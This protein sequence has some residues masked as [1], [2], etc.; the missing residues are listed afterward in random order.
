MHVY[1]FMKG[2][3]LYQDMFYFCTTLCNILYIDLHYKF[4]LYFIYKM[5]ATG[6]CAA[7]YV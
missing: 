4:D 1:T 2:R 6:D 3:I 5:L 7:Y